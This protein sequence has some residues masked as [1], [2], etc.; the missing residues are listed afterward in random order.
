MPFS[1]L[2]GLLTWVRNKL[3][4]IGFLSSKKHAV[5]VISIGNLSMGGTGKTPFTEFLIRT[6][7]E[8]LKLATLSRGYGRKTRGFVLADERAKAST[9]G[10]EPMQYFKKFKSI[11]VA[12]S[13]N[14]NLGVKKLTEKLPNLDLVLLDDAFQHRFITPGL[15]ILL[16]DFYNLYTDDYVFPSGKL[17]E[18]KSGANRAGI[19]IVT[20]TPVVLSPITRRR[21]SRELKLKKNQLL[22]FSKIQYGELQPF[23]K[24]GAKVLKK[25]Y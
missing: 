1:F 10:D 19:V 11:S 24:S 6:F 18:Y 3:F 20:K 25:R 23:S 16:T 21:I 14:R 22:L 9:I 5:P 15:N 13:E 2:Y 8:N 17:R 7:Q 4:D 12:V